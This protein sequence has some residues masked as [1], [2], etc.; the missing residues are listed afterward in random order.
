MGYGRVGGCEGASAWLVE[1]ICNFREA[2]WGRDSVAGRDTAGEG[3]TGAWEGGWMVEGK[4]E[5][6]GWKLRDVTLGV[7]R[8]KAADE[9][10]ESY[11]EGTD[12]EGFG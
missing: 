4:V 11:P 12:C 10:G 7:G 8:R 2:S 6:G 3:T 1:G 9:P 5:E